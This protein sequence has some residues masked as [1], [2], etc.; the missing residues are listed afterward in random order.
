[1]NRLDSYTPLGLLA[2]R[3]RRRGRRRAPRSS[4][5][6][7]WSPRPA[8][9][10]RCT[11]RSTGCPINLCV[12]VPDGVAAEHAAFATVGAIAMQGVRRAEVA[13]RRDGLRHRARADRPAR[14]PA[15]RRLRR[16]GRRPR[17]GRGPLP[18]GREGRRAALRRARTTTASRRSSRCC[19]SATGGLGADHVFLAAGGDSNGPVE[20]AARLARD[21][22][23]VVDIGKTRLDLPVERLLREGA[24]RPLLAVLRA[25]SLRRPRTSSR[26]STTRPATSAGPS[27]ATSACFLDLLADGS[28]DVATLVSGVHPIEEA[29]RGLRAAGRRVAAGHRL[30]ASL[31]RRRS[32]SAPRRAHACRHRRPPRRRAGPA[33]PPVGRHR[34]ARLH[35]RRQLRH[36]DAAAAPREAT[37]AS[38]WSRWPRPGRCRRSTPSASSASSTITTDADDG[39]RR[40]DARRRLRRD[41]APLARRLRL[42]GA[43]AR[44][45]RL[46]REAARPRPRSSSTASST[47]SSGPATTG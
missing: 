46:R 26:A 11:P 13:A 23:R 35:R 8:T 22:A 44:Q 24:R 45:G 28:V 14:R 1:M 30:P 37:P 38:T 19:S 42:P 15:A 41:A 4:R 16:P 18:G 33:E 3:R 27:G 17:H 25:G 40:P 6:A 32:P 31:P 12:P 9:S 2:V 29:D 20:V 36:L 7:S 10:S 34:A 21:R 39:P 5:S 47:P 43:R